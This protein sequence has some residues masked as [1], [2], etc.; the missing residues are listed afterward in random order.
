MQVPSPFQVLPFA[1][2]IVKKQITIKVDSETL[3]N[4]KIITTRTGYNMTS[5]IEEAI[6]KYTQALIKSDVD[7]QKAIIKFK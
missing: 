2:A 1:S 4:I 3:E 7:I 6:K 5:G